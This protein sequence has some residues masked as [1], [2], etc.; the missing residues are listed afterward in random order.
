MKK[1]KKIYI[2]GHKNPDT[3]SICSAIAYADI[4]NRTRE[5]K[6]LAKRAGQLNEETQFVLNYFNVE[7]PGYLPD[8]GTQV[9]DMEL[10]E[11]PGA[12]ADMSV[13]RAWKLMKEN[14]AATL[15]IIKKDGTLEGLISTGDI[16]MS[17]HDAYDNRIL[18][19]A[20][21]QYRS[22]A[23][24]LDG[25]VIVG[26][27][28]AYL[29]HGKTWIGASQ[30]G[31]METFLEED[32]LV[33]LGNRMEDYLCAIEANAS[34]IVGCLSPKVSQT[35]QRLAAERSV[36]IITTAYDTYTVARL[37]QQSIPIRFIMKT[38]NL[39]CFRS[40]DFTDRIKDTMSKY[41]YHAFPVVNK[42]G[43]YLG[44]VSRRNFLNIDKKQLILVDHNEK[45]QAVD[46]IHEAEIL[47]IIDHHRIG[48]LETFQPVMFR[49]QPVG[50]TATIMY[51]IYGENKL[52]VP[53][54]MAGLLC[55][56]ILSDTLMFRSPT[57]TNQDVKAAQ[58]LA[59]IAGIQIEE[60]AEQM[61][62]A[63]SNLSSK[64]PEEIFYQDYKKFIVDKLAFGVGQISFMSEEE[65][66]SVKD[67]L[68]PFM[69]KECG[70]QGVS[71]VFFMLTNIIKE[72][73]L[74]I[75]CGQ[76][77]EQLI[78][79]AFHEEVEN[80]VCRLDG[81]VSRKKQLIPRFMNALQQ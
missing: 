73:T 23:D 19:Q 26:N 58:E 44:T 24:T 7:A 76:G 72:S 9:K 38:D 25:E 60:F 36:V 32:D 57:C 52:E 48:S 53:A 20:K 28:H 55:A 50:C 5:E 67:R 69:E 65:L 30:P 15:P 8:V 11:T 17:Y 78:M 61:F 18:S 66:M 14:S 13:K 34:C 4:K 54:N 3:D 1:E 42:K 10:H 33:I 62:R 22:I 31:I 12:S 74:L 80:N 79:D 71:M 47:E 45:S 41:R 43:E 59:E 6:Y 77:V 49:N 40:D 70:S 16:A 2:I 35:I 51:Q 46:N 68:I 64:T 56:A 39:I 81:V 75:C 27:E 29:C 37:I 21:T 63:G